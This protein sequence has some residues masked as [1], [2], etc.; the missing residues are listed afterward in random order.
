MSKAQL[1]LLILAVGCAGHMPADYQPDARP[2]DAP[3]DTL[4]LDAAPDALPDAPP[5]QTGCGPVGN[6]PLSRT[7][8]VDDSAPVPSGLLGEIQDQTVGARHGLKTVTIPPLIVSQR[9]AGSWAQ[10]TSVNLIPCIAHIANASA[11]VGLYFPYDDAI[12]VT[13]M[14]VE[15]FGDGVNV[16]Q[17]QVLHQN[18][19]LSGATQ[20][21]T[22][23]ALDAGPPAVGWA[24]YSF[25]NPDHSPL[26][27]FL[28]NGAHLYKILAQFTTPGV[29]QVGR[30]RVTYYR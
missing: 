23:P 19:I 2:P 3:S 15:V 12:T 18:T 29:A 9:P 16:G 5:R 14:T 11:F 27:P 25:A 26:T 30:L 20:V 6:L 4:Q 1:I 24:I 28:I 17:I 21:A 8:N 10:D 7:A 22:L 13:A